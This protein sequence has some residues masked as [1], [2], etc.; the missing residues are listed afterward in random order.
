MN[1]F[2]AQVSVNGGVEILLGERPASPCP[3]R[4]SR[5]IRSSAA[6]TAAR[7]SR[8][9]AAS[10]SIR[11][12]SGRICRRSRATV[13]L[14]EALGSESIVY[15][16]VDAR[17]VREGQHAEVEEEAAVSAEGV[18]ASRPNLVAEFPAHAIVRLHEQMSIAVEVARAHF[19]DAETG[20]PLR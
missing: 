9:S 14:V 1:L 19:F 4:R 18:V 6:T 2:E 5:R 20:E 15:F 7:W 13:D 16:R 11:R 10:F 12:P 3:T 17:A 8:A